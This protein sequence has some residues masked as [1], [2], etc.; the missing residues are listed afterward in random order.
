M[1]GTRVALV[2]G[3]Y[4]LGAIPNGLLIA[5]LRGIDIR[6][7]GSGNIGATNVF[8]CVGKGWG[9]LT[10]VLDALKGFIPAVLFP[11]LAAAC[12]GDAEPRAWRLLYVAAAIAGHNWPVYLGFKGGKGVATSAGGLLGV[13]PAA[14]GI[15]LAI[16]L[17]AFVISRYVSLASIVASAAVCAAGWSFFAA[18]RR[19]GLHGGAAGWAIPLFLTVLAAAIIA[20]HRANIARLLAGTENRFDFRRRRNAPPAGGGPEAPGAKRGAG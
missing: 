2:A 11:L 16:W 20:R 10:F 12:A 6:K 5:R 15:G 8:R 9:I 13:A 18:E 14:M 3:A 1:V 19:A 17:A 4:L 7:V